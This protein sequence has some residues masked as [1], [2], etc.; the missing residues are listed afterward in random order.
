MLTT[1]KVFNSLVKLGFKKPTKQM[2]IKVDRLNHDNLRYPVY[3]KPLLEESL[4]RNYVLAIH[5][6]YLLPEFESSDFRPRNEEL[7]T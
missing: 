2:N 7:K 1:E 6:Q 3:V 4:K 5:P